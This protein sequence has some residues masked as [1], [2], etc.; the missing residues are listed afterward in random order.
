M[1]HEKNLPKLGKFNEKIFGAHNKRVVF[2]FAGMG[3]R[4]WLYSLSI[5]RLVKH[6]YKVVAY[7]FAA[8]IV[9]N[10]DADNLLDVINRVSRSVKRHIETFQKAGDVSFAVFGVSMGT[11][12]AIKVAG[13]N[14]AIKKVVINLTYG[15][16]AENIWTWKLM[17]SARGRSIEQGYSMETL[18]QKL[19]PVSPIPNAVR[20]KGKDV[21]LYLSRKD[22]ILLFEQSRQFKDALDHHAVN[23]T[24]VQNDKRGHIIAGYQNMRNHNRWLRFLSDDF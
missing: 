1:R 4:T 18:D 11:L 9:K 17:E 22:K 19:A 5:R 14:D 23:Y 15:S 16:V 7:D 20:L 21:L 3:T 8:G 6:D 24:Y 12:M 13:E 10:G 2:F